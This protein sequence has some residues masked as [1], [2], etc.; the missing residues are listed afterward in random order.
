MVGVVVVVVVVVV[1]VVVVVVVTREMGMEWVVGRRVV[2]VMDI[3]APLGWVQTVLAEV[4]QL[5]MPR[6]ASGHVQP[7]EDTLWVFGG[8]VVAEF[9]WTRKDLTTIRAFHR[10][11]LCVCLDVGHQIRSSQEGRSTLQAFEQWGL[12][13]MHPFDVGRD[14]AFEGEFFAAD[15]ALERLLARVRAFVLHQGAL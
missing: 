4:M 2:L 11:Q 8:H 14:P 15:G 6:K 1:A 13:Q 10:F 5:M 9:N 12:V 7:G 3:A